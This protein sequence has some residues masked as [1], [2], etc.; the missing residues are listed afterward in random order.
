MEV[1]YKRTL[2]KEISTNNIGVI[3][4]D[5]KCFKRYLDIAIV[6][7]NKV[8]VITDNDRSYADNITQNYADYFNY[9][10]IGIWSD[11]SDE[12]YTFEVCMYNDN[13]T[14]CEAEFQT[15]HRRLPILDYMLKNKAEAAYKLL[16]NRADSIAVPQYIQDAIRWIDA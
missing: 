12:R 10:N 5:G 11:T 4:V 13:R 9:P 2:A 1:L 7:E 6:L 3:A 15:P 8:A 16:K 14:T